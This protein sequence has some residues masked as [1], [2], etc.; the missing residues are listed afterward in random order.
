M[1]ALFGFGADITIESSN[2]IRVNSAIES[3]RAN[4]LKINSA[5]QV[6]V[7][8][9]FQQG[10]LH[11]AYHG[12]CGTRIGHASLQTHVGGVTGK[13][14]Y[15]SAWPHG[16]QGV[17]AQNPLS[18]VD[19]FEQDVKN[20]GGQPDLSLN[21]YS[22]NVVRINQ[23]FMDFKQKHLD[24]LKGVADTG[25][26]YWVLLAPHYKSLFG[27]DLSD[28]QLAESVNCSY[29]TYALM[30]IGG[31]SV[32]E[33]K[34]ENLLNVTFALTGASLGVLWTAY[35]AAHPLKEGESVGVSDFLTAM[36]LGVVGGLT[37]K[38]IG[39]M[40]TK[41]GDGQALVLT[42]DGVAKIAYKLQ[43]LEDYYYL[44]ETTKEDGS[45]KLSPPRYRT[46]AEMLKAL[47]FPVNR[48]LQFDQALLRSVFAFIFKSIKNALAPTEAFVPEEEARMNAFLSSLEALPLEQLRGLLEGLNLPA[49]AVS[50]LSRQGLSAP[51]GGAGG[52][53]FT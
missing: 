8:V 30:S 51:L 22:L 23:A 46:T 28:E 25:Q 18:L 43:C 7:H 34:Y 42:P 24:A 3:L 44:R 27:F 39:N 13:G 26:A 5:S 38:G 31:L 20:E 1:L 4:A 48:A 29:L 9:W 6:T 53:G 35:R 36:L 33:Q 49:S 37:F 15:A 40:I 10:D 47:L 41:L 16:I 17:K 12:V 2:G 45:I 11:D 21:L 32:V 52:P 50:G 14:I 19:S